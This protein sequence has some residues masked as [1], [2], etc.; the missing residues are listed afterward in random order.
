MGACDEGAVKDERH[1]G[2]PGSEGL[3]NVDGCGVCWH[4][5]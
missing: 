5:A 1:E 4:L 3:K 2:T